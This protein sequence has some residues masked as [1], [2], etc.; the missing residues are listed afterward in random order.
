MTPALIRGLPFA[1]Y[2]ALPGVHVSTL[3]HMDVS[4]LHYRHACDHGSAP[5]PS[6]MLGQICHAAILTPDEPVGVAVYDGNRTGKRWIEFELEHGHKTIVRRKELDASRAMRDAVMRHPE[7]RRLLSRGEGEVSMQWTDADTGLPCK[8]R[9]DW[10]TS[11]GQIVEVKTTRAIHPRAFASAC[12]RLM[13]HA[14][15]A[16]YD[17]GLHAC[18]PSS[19]RQLPALIA[20]ENLPPHDVAVYRVGFDALEAGARKVAEWM[21][22]LAACEADRRWPGV[23]GDGTLDLRLPDWA[24]SDG[25]DIDIG[26]LEES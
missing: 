12:A 2:L 25:D 16:F 11:D 20:V 26:A 5:S 14:Q 18:A 22:V 3:K 10:L 24:L 19:A 9:L 13:Y 4:A 7:A 23:G 6:M 8:G 15:I 17:V 21:R 1:D